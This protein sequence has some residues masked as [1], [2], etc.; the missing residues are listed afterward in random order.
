MSAFAVVYVYRGWVNVQLVVAMSGD[1]ARQIV[2]DAMVAEE[3]TG[4]SIL[5]ATPLPRGMYAAVEEKRQA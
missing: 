1:D 4:F 2:N 3:M 5:S